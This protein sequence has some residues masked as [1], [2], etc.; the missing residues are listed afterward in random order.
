VPSNRDRIGRIIPLSFRFS[1]TIHFRT[2]IGGAL[3]GEAREA[4][5][6][7]LCYRFHLDSPI[8][9]TKSLRDDDRA[10]ARKRALIILGFHVA[11][12]SRPSLPR[13]VPRMAR[14][15]NSRCRYVARRRLSENENK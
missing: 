7:F 6:L 15:F 8:K 11:L 13:R 9:F 4:G 12:V 2:A 3:T 1:V 10:G 14:L 5:R